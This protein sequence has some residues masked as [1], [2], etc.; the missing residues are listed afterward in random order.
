MANSSKQPRDYLYES[1]VKICHSWTALQIAVNQG[2]GGPESREKGECFPGDLTEWLVKAC[3]NLDP[4]NI[5]PSEIEE[6]L[7]LMMSE[8]FD[9]VVEDDSCKLISMLLYRVLKAIHTQDFQMYCQ[10]LEK[11]PKQADVGHS[12]H[13][14]IDSETD[15]EDEDTPQSSIPQPKPE[16]QPKPEPV[17]DDDGFEMV[18]PK[19]STGKRSKKYEDQVRRQMELLQDENESQSINQPATQGDSNMEM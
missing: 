3:K 12:E 6:T 2:F 5:D 19:K 7:L 17:V 10:L 13:K 1:A 14:Q 8:W 15:G 16:R 11:L 9:T 18:A 4:K